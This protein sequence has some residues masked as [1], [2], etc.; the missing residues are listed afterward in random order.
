M[1][2]ERES[3]SCIVRRSLPLAGIALTLG[4]SSGTF[5]RAQ[6]LD[7]VL[8]SLDTPVLSLPVASRVRAPKLDRPRTRIL[9]V[10]SPRN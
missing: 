2:R 9:L 10:W 1:S 7:L 4:L 5:A 3:I 6:T 8:E